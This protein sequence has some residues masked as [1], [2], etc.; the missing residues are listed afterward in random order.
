MLD[1]KLDLDCFMDGL[2]DFRIWVKRMLKD[3]I[4]LVGILVSGSLLALLSVLLQRLE[5]MWRAA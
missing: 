2:G 3:L 4:E 5:G 1:E